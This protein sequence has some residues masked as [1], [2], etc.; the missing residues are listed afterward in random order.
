MK[1]KNNKKFSKKINKTK[2]LSNII[3][4]YSPSINKQLD[5]KSLKSDLPNNINIC[6]NLLKINIGNTK[7]PKCLDYNNKSVIKLL[8]NNLKKSK[9]LDPA[10]FIAPKQLYANCWFNTMYVAFFFS[11]KGRKFFRFF[12]EYMIKGEKLNNEKISDKKLQELFYILNLHIEASYNQ[13]NN[14]ELFN[15]IKSITKNLYTNYFI[16]N[17]HDRISYLTY[18]KVPAIN[19]AGN[20]IS[21]YKTLMN[22]MN[23]N[24]LKMNELDI[25]KK[26]NIENI[27]NNT[28]NKIYNIPEIII[29]NDF[30]SKSIYETNYKILINDIKYHYVLDSI[31]LTNKG[32]FDPKK[33]SHFVC[34]LTINNEEYKFDG[35]SYNKLTKFNWKKMINENKDWTFSENPNYYPEKY[36]FTKGY[37]ILFYYRQTK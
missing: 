29:L 24:I 19:E 23:Y 7:N 32:H 15:Q 11:D 34:V 10:K 18:K 27:L 4:S 28:F 2:K 16:K 12:R 5:V 9:Y 26:S 36:N 14:K 21:F 1:T 30:E 22:Y 25:Q 37:K 35:D 13:N 3:K 31:I 6:N 20:P 17:I 8:L 33:N